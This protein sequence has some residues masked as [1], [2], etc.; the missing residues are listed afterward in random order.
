M[1]VRATAELQSSKRASIEYSSP[2]ANSS[3]LLL[4]LNFVGQRQHLLTATT[5]K[6]FA[7][8]SKLVDSV[9]PCTANMTSFSACF[10]SVATLHWACDCGLQLKGFEGREAVQRMAGKVADIATLA[11]ARALGMFFT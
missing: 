1:R 5:C 10:A 8:C 4:V 9:Q 2:L 6:D 3:I 11:E 7:E